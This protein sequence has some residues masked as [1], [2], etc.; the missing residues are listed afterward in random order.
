MGVRGSAVGWDTALQAEEPLVRFPRVKQSH[1]IPGQSPRVPGARG[2]QISRQSAHEGGKFVSPTHRPPLPP[3]N[4]P[5]THFCWRLSSPQGHTAAGRIMSV[6]NNN[7]TIGNRTRDLPACSAVPRPPAP[8][9]IPD[10]QGCHWNF[11]CT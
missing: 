8:P 9:R 2:S 1:Y 10:S 5:G 7:D 11:S 4:I 3:E 6:K